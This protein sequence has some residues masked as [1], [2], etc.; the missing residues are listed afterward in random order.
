MS[1]SP[2]Q[3]FWAVI[4]TVLGV[5]VVDTPGNFVRRVLLE[6]LNEIGYALRNLPIDIF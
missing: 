3:M 5:S 1:H 6:I 2:S 4:L